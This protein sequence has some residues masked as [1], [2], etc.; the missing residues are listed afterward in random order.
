MFKFAHQFHSNVA[1]GIL[2]TQELPLVEQSPEF[3][4]Q[5]NHLKNHFDTLAEKVEEIALTIKNC[6]KNGPEIEQMVRK[7]FHRWSAFLLKLV[8]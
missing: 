6:Q 2:L 3:E 8:H 5:L 1:L 4:R 7:T